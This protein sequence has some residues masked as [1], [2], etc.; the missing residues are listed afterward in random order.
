LFASKLSF[1]VL[2]ACLGVI[3][4]LTREPVFKSQALVCDLSEGK[5]QAILEAGST[6]SRVIDELGLQ[7]HPRP[8]P[9]Y[10]ISKNRFL[11]LFH[12]DQPAASDHFFRNVRFESESVEAFSLNFLSDRQFVVKDGRG[13]TLGSA[14]LN[15]PMDYGPFA[16]TLIEKPKRRHYNLVPKVQALN[17][18]K[19]QFRLLPKKENSALLVCEY[20]A[21]DRLLP[22]QFLNSLFSDNLVIEPIDRPWDPLNPVPSFFWIYAAAG[23]LIGFLIHFRWMRRSDLAPLVNDL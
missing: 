3:F 5:G 18:V 10:K 16:F 7:V 17:S 12:R 9:W 23:G 22:A 21:K 4:P 2:G 15:Q 11:P 20:R 6:H 13:I 19:E 14:F 8:L 1:I